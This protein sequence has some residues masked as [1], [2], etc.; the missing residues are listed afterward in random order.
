MP[1]PLRTPP[2]TCSLVADA[3]ECGSTDCH[4]K[5]TAHHRP[6]PQFVLWSR[7]FSFIS[8]TLTNHIAFANVSFDRRDSKLFNGINQNGGCRVFSRRKRPFSLDGRHLATSPLFFHS[9]HH[10]SMY[11]QTIISHHSTGHK[12]SYRLVHNLPHFVPF[13]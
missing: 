12:I 8:A 3:T 6:L 13:Q 10:C 1:P 9:H 5:A 4:R 7:A 2:A 11:N